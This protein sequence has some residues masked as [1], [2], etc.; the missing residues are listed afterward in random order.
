MHRALVVCLFVSVLHAQT[1]SPD[2]VRSA[3]TRAVAI[4][5]HGSTGF[6]ELMQ[7]FSCHDHALPMLALRVARER[8]V[9]VDEA[10]ASQVAAKG[11]LYSPDLTSIDHAVQDPMIVDPASD[12]GWALVAAH[13]VGVQPNLVTAVYARRV[14]NWQRPEGYWPT[15]DD[16]PPQSYSLFT[17][18]AVALRAMQ[19]YMPTKSH[20]EVDER[21]AR[22]KTWLLT[23]QPHDTED[24][25]FRLFGLHWAG[26]TPDERGRAVQDLL[27]LQRSNGGWAEIPHM[28]PDAYSTGEALVALHEAG[29]VA[30]TDPAWQKGLQYLLSTQEADGSWHVHTRMLSPAAVS[31]PYFETGFPYEH[32]QFLSTAATC[33]ASM[34]LMLNL[35]KAAKP[36]APQPPAALSPQGLEP[37]METALFGTASELKAQ[38][39]GGLDPNSK[40]PEGTTLLMMAAHDAEKVKLLIDRG[41]DVRAN[42]KSGYTALMV[43]TTYLGTSPSVKLLL[44]HGAEARPGKG[45]MFEASPL[46][47]AALTGDRDN[48]ALLLAKGADPN[49]RMEIIGMFPTSPL[50]EAVFFGDPAIVKVLVQGGADVREKDL[51]GMTPL[52]WAVVAHRPEAAKAL[53]DAGAD[54][55]AVDRFGYTPLLYAATIDFGDPEA[56]TA[57]LQ[58]GADLSI[59]TKEGKTPLA[60]A[61]EYP[62]I[63]AALEKAGAKP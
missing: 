54:V 29:G 59:K 9:A 49:R 53:L 45:V 58:A 36:S 40:T 8:G 57:L 6:S 13:A 3:A 63:R 5:Q 15:L 20:Q 21:R 23:A 35:P 16:R 10:A 46:F 50:I 44:E 43:A 30:V 25:T 17:A 55:N 47:L 18:T 19:L 11:L 51:D 61:R 1:A 39:D 28:Q 42:A 52:H 37:W 48:V 12:D 2:Q 62:Y 41:A 14:A 24:F 32:D 4:V 33:W 31:P 56:A 26:A 38:L 34:A 7:C 60:Q 27:A 22:A